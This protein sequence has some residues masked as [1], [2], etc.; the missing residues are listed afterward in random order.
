MTKNEQQL[1]RLIEKHQ[2]IDDEVDRLSL[3]NLLLPSERTR[4]KKLKM[5]RLHARRAVEKYKE[6][7]LDLI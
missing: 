4:L 6:R 1:Q 3:Q 7:F 5:E 2:K